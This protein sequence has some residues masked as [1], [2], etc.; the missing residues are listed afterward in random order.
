MTTD[1]ATPPTGSTSQTPDGQ[2]GPDYV[3]TVSR[4]MLHDIFID[5]YAQMAAIKR[6]AHAVNL[7][8]N[9]YP[10]ARPFPGSSVQVQL[11]P[12][13]ATATATATSTASRL[14]PIAA[15][16]LA[17]TGVLGP[18]GGL[19]LGM[20]ANQPTSTPTP[21]V[22]VNPPPAIVAPEQPPAETGVDHDTRYNLNVRVE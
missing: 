4:S 14:L 11:P 13:P 19:L 3:R 21:A 22:N 10:Y 20:L 1:Q 9:P 16:A 18:I 2:S 5:D 8:L 7:G 12:Q 6:E 17:A 15:G